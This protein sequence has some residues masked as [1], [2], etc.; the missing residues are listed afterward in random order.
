VA[1]RSHQ[2]SRRR[3]LARITYDEQTAAAFKEV[4]EVP[5]DGL[6][7]WREAVGRHLRPS[8]GMTLVDIGAGTGAFAAAFSD[9]FD[10]SVLAVEPSAAM[11]D[12]IPRTPAIEVLAGSASVL[13][14]PDESADAAW[15]SLVI[16]HVPDLEVAAHEIRRVLRP[17][18]PVLIR[19]GF[20][21]TNH[22]G[23]EL[24]R[25]FPETAR[26]IDTF[27]SVAETCSSFA[28]AEFD[29]DALEQVRE[30]HPTS[31]ADF[32][33][34]VDTFRHADTTMR[35]LTE[36]EFA[37]GKERLR[38]AVRLAR[39]TANLEPRSNW[40]DLLVLR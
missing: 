18:A 17:G 26:T 12:Q 27:P 20:A 36:D 39:N 1:W 31:L 3:D 40:L 10:L 4:R 28:A 24:V 11:R 5:R 34:Q 33:G 30:T 19:Q 13:P 14:L 22:D 16:H 15:L 2:P 38:R 9:W 25:W 37:R 32:L 7:E 29:M 8:Q 6:S 23:I 35:D 21:G